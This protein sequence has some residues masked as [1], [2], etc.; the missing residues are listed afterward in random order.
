[1]EY[2]YSF[3]GAKEMANFIKRNHF[4]NYMIIAHQSNGANAL[5]PYLPEK[6]FWYAGIEDYGTFVTYN[7]KHLAGRSIS[8]EQAI[9]RIQKTFP[10]T[11]QLLILLTNPLDFPELYGFRLLYKVDKDVFG[12]GH[13]RFYLYKPVNLK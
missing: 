6:V 9:L 2:K 4:D 8:N 10:A 12:Y 11:S 3:S 1:M 13:E 7:K 5:L